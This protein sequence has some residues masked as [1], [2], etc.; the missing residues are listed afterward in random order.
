DIC[1]FNRPFDDQARIR[2]KLETQ[3]KLHIQD[4]IK[5]GRIELCWSYVLDYENSVN[6]FVERKNFVGNWKKISRFDVNENQSI[7]PQASKLQK[8]GLHG[9]DALHLA[10]AVSASCNFFF[11]TDDFILKKFQSFGKLKILNPIDFLGVLEKS[12]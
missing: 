11:T 12:K 3:A 9:K 1:C 7:L 10:S 6:P 8:Q 5:Q 4:E 2:I